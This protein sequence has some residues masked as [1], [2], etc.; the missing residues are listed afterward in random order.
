MR[1]HLSDGQ[2]LEVTRRHIVAAVAVVLLVLLAYTVFTSV[3]QVDPREEGVVLTL[4]T[5]TRTV[6]P[7]LYVKWPYPIS[8]VYIVPTQVVDEEKFGYRTDEQGRRM[9]ET[10]ESERHMLTGDLNIVLA[11]WDVQFTRHEPEKYLFNVED[12]EETLRDI[13]QSV[14]RET[15]GDMASIRSLTVGRAEIIEQARRRIQQQVDRFDMGIRISEVNLTFVDP[16]PPVQ[17][18]FDDLNKAVQDADR[19]FQEASRQY[20]ERVPQA[21]GAAQR[22]QRVAEGHR[23]RRVER[24]EGQAARF[25]AMLE[26]YRQA[27]EVTRER[28]FLET[29]E[30]TLG[31]VDRVILID[32]DLDS[33]L[34]HWGLD[35]ERP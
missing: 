16:P 28:L 6:G 4:G 10:Y 15:L 5:H 33:I 24:A 9:M 11:G 27:P 22:R 23:D 29:M 17:S 34:P 7:G 18:A 32:P 26:Q 20:E 19:F 31:G 25:N 3:F 30:Q 14:M 2:V 35:G 13:A 8:R 1:I 21:R 12:P